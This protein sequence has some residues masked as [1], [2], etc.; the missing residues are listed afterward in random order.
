MTSV[1]KRPV[2]PPPIQGKVWSA[3]TTTQY[4]K[5]SV[6]VSGRIDPGKDINRL[7]AWLEQAQAWQETP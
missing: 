7:K 3:F 2:P 6:C 4:G 5:K 1:V